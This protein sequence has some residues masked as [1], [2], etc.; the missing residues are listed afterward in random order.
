MIPPQPSGTECRRGF[1]LLEILLVIGILGLLLGLL[2]PAVQSVRESS[3][4]MQCASHLRQMVLASQN[5]ADTHGA[6]PPIAVSGFSLTNNLYCRLFPYLEQPTESVPVARKIPVL[7]CPSD[8]AANA[9]PSGVNY[10]MNAGPRRDD[11]F[12][13]NGVAGG[14]FSTN[15]GEVVRWRDVIDGASNTA[16]WSERVA[17]VPAS[18]AAAAAARPFPYLW[19]AT[20]RDPVPSSLHLQRK[21][22][23]AACLSSTRQASPNATAG[24]GFSWQNGSNAFYLHCDLINSGTCTGTLLPSGHFD[25]T[26]PAQSH[27]PGGVNVAFLDGQVRLVSDQID[28]TLWMALGTRDGGEIA[29]LGEL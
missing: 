16:A 28:A 24:A 15:P 20:G 6:L 17:V 21:A 12:F 8:G 23:T 7:L 29:G 11:F 26:R 27:H 9:H 13:I 14:H 25:S 19:T 2:A 10:A 1:S 22:I 18:S 5:Y 4:R 3:R